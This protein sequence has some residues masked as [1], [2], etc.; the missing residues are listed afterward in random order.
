M[1]AAGNT[2]VLGATWRGT[3]RAVMEIQAVQEESA[4]ADYD[5][6]RPLQSL[7]ILVGIS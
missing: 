6:R 5:G 2:L 1:K 4:Q 7:L 3:K